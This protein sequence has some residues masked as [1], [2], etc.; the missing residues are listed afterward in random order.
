MT[1]WIFDEKVR[2]IIYKLYRQYNTV[3]IVNE[4]LIGYI[5]S[6]IYLHIWVLRSN[7][8]IVYFP[9]PYYSLFSAAIL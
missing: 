1:F 2:S 5:R 3:L 9:Q 7:H 4:P 6:I 8:T